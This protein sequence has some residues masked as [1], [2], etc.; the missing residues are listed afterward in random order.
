MDAQPD[1]PQARSRGRRGEQPHP[2]P[3]PAIV[4]VHKAHSNPTRLRSISPSREGSSHGHGE[5]Y[6]RTEARWLRGPPP[7][8]HSRPR[9]DR[10]ARGQPAARRSGRTA[11]G[12]MWLS[13]S[14]FLREGP[15]PA[16]SSISFPSDV[17]GTWGRPV[18]LRLPRSY[19][20]WSRDRMPP[21][22]SEVL[23]E[24]CASAD[25][26]PTSIVAMRRPEQRAI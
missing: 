6:V 8:P 14:G 1:R 24:R 23:R 2:Y 4:L 13:I 19:A 12:R 9:Q 20:L 22:R 17:A 10:V 25:C 21:S 15:I 5:Q 18:Y 7:A 11:W 26:S 16:A 3:S